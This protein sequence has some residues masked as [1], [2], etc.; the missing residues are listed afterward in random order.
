MLQNADG[1]ACQ[2][3]L[4]ILYNLG[5]RNPLFT[6]SIAVSSK[7][8]HILH[9]DVSKHELMVRQSCIAA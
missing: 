4:R 9:Q 6:G 8:H 5:T 2:I 7:N 1:E 3:F